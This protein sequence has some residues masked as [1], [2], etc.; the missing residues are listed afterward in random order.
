M[1][2][3][4]IVILSIIYLFLAFSVDHIVPARIFLF[5]AIALF[6]WGYFEYRKENFR[7]EDELIE[8]TEKEILQFPHTQRIVSEDYLTALLLDE[9]NNKVCI[10][11]KEDY[12]EKFREIEVDFHQ[13]YEAAIV[14]DGKILTLFSK[15]GFLA[16]SLLE[17]GGTSVIHLSETEEQNEKDEEENDGL[18]D[19]DV[20]DGVFKL[21]I[22]IVID[23]LKK[24]IVEFSFLESDEP[25]LKDS[26]E[27]KDL[28]KECTEWHQK[29][30]IIIKRYEKER[31]PVTRWS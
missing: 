30:S 2:I 13:L 12:D 29:L 28:L 7:R 17:E 9:Q 21:S 11:K 16:G 15:G 26:E 19:R 10:L 18:G 24:P 23:D 27:Y 14:E 5:L 31:V 20:E 4:L 1:K 3:I 22:K 8:E 6:I 25:I